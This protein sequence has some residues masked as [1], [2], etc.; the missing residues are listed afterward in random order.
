MNIDKF[1][2]LKTEYKSIV[3]TSVSFFALMILLF[4]IEIF[5]FWGIYGEGATASRISELWYVEIILDYLPIVIIGV[6][7]G[8]KT[9]TKYKNRK[10]IEFKT[11]MITLMILFVLFLIRNKI[12]RLFF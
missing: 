6:Y 2:R 1:I 8:I 5:V 4:I 12:Q 3:I 7:L 11:N 9:F 10:F